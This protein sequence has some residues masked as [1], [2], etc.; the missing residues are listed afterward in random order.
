MPRFRALV[1]SLLPAALALI[2][3]H[4]A[5]QARVSDH[6]QISSPLMRAVEPPDPNATPDDLEAQGDELRRQKL[7]LD[8]LDYYRTANPKNPNSARLFNK[9]GICEL[10]LQRYPEAKKDFERAIKYD[11][12]FSDAYNN[13]GVIYYVAKKYPK[14]VGRYEKAIELRPESA[15]F[16]SNMGAAYFSMKDFQRSVLA[17]AHALQL[18]PDVFERSSHGGIAA[19]MAKPEDR[20]HYDYVVA[21]LYA[22]MGAT[23]RSLQYLR[24]AMEEGYKGIEDVYKDSEFADL[25]KDPRFTELM[26]ARP[27]GI[28]N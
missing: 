10:L 23:D 18:D 2:V 28:P 26:G 7:F 12:T 25:R 9:I 22:K 1:V 17:Y 16:Y 20:A 13:L 3:A 6:V 21:K 27:L 11:R 5:A 4:A 8:A 15:S 14:A 24:R 19:Q